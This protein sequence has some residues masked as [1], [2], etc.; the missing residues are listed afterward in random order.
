MP[1]PKLDPT[2]KFQFSGPINETKGPPYS[3]MIARFPG[4]NSE[5]PASSG[6]VMKLIERSPE[7][8][9]L[10]KKEMEELLVRLFLTRKSALRSP[11]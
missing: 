1:F 2:G 5:H 6:Y 9:C 4:N 7:I 11:V 3:V 8:F 10:R